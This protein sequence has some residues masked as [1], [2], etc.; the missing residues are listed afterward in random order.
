MTITIFL[1]YV[2]VA[3]RYS[4]EY[5]AEPIVQ[6]LSQG[7]VLGQCAKAKTDSDIRTPVDG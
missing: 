3:T 1:G 7:T 4:L 2:N 5:L 6:R